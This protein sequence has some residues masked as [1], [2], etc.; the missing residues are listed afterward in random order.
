MKKSEKLEF[1]RWVIVDYKVG[2]QNTPQLY[3][4]DS[5][6]EKKWTW[7]QATNIQKHSPTQKLGEHKKSSV[8]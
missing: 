2:E 3:K 4:K 1:Q 5:P 8:R 7:N 6:N